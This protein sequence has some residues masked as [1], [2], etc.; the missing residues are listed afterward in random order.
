MLMKLLSEQCRIDAKHVEVK[1]TFSIL[2]DTLSFDC[3]IQNPRVTHVEGVV[4]HPTPP[5]CMAACMGEG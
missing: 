2:S 3:I 5:V 4:V 1:Y